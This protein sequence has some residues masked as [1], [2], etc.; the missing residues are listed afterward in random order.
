MEQQNRHG[1]KCKQGVVVSNKMDKTV[2]VRVSRRFRHP[3]YDKVLERAKKY[4][5]HN[6][7]KGVDIGDVVEIYETKPLSKLKRWRV[8]RVVEKAAA[9]VSIAEIG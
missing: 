4:Y 2:T 8:E 1:R 6:E 5:A 3:K 7:V 9:P